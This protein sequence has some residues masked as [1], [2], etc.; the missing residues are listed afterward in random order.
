[1]KSYFNYLSAVLWL[2]TA[3][4]CTK[5]ES[6]GTDHEKDDGE[7]SITASFVNDQTWPETEEQRKIYWNPG[8]EINVF[9]V[10]KYGKLV[11]ELPSPAV[12]SRFTGDFNFEFG[13]QGGG[14]FLWALYPYKENAQCNGAEILTTLPSVQTGKEGSFSKEMNIAIAVSETPS[15]YFRFVC[16]G[17]RFSVTRDDVRQAVLQSRDRESLAGDVTV[18]FDSGDPV[19]KKVYDGTSSITL[20]APDGGTFKPGK[21]YYIVT[22]PSLLKKGFWLTFNTKDKSATHNHF[23]SIN[24]VRSS[25]ESFPD[26]DSGLEYKDKLPEPTGKNITFKNP[27]T[28]RFCLRYDTDNDGELSYEEAAA[29]KSL[30]FFSDGQLTEFDEFRFF[31]GLTS[32]PAGAFTECQSLRTITI[33]EG[34]KAIGSNAFQYCEKLESVTILGDV[35]ESIG[36]RAFA[37][38]KSLES[39]DFPPDLHSLGD[40]AFFG[41]SSLKS[42]VI[43]D[44]VREVFPNVFEDCVSLTSVQFPRL[45]SVIPKG[46]F[47]GCISLEEIVYPENAS[48]IEEE[49]FARCAFFK[50]GVSRMDVP[51]SVKTIRSEGI[52]AAKNVFLTSMTPVTIEG[53]PF[54]A[55]ARIFVPSSLVAGYKS[56]PEWKHYSSR[57]YPMDEY[58]F[59]ESESHAPE[60]AVD[61]GL[62]VFWS[63]SN[64][65]ASSPEEQGSFF[66]WGEI[67]TKKYQEEWSSY[68][69]TEGD[70]AKLTKYNT[71][72]ESGVV[73]GKTILDPEDDV[74]SVRLGGKFRMPTLEDYRE[75]YNLC[76]WTMLETGDIPCFKITSRSNGNSIVIPIGPLYWTSELFLE[77]PFQAW[78]INHYPDDFHEEAIDMFPASSYRFEMMCVRPVSDK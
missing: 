57:I 9:Y 51:A 33:P 14:K 56:T 41:C 74:A 52:P 61:L 72:E 53:M 28:K 42:I 5:P 60:G 11:S 32:L 68:R 10:L 7:F 38:C 4:S 64:L 78:Y 47:K 69:W 16:S 46:M 37:F 18:T 30:S 77:D 35:L 26:A 17:I 39:I 31:T 13:S 40:R 6:Q 48:I 58:P 23:E 22:I 66:S 25:F 63:S 70:P 2:I 65:G 36:S 43:P 21:W 71:K 73:D 1:M 27:V 75:L 54:A 50:E 62:S 55:Y 67:Q 34:I 29:V 76:L 44:S 3:V 49:A 59:P 20:N 19:V 24:I 15:F 8:D 45:L 12:E